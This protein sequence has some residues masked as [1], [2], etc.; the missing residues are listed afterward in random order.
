MAVAVVTR[1]PA[2]AGFGLD[3]LIDASASCVLVW[4]FSMARQ[5]DR[6]AQRI[7]HIVLRSVGV[8]LLIAAVYV[9]ARSIIQLAQ[10]SAS[11]ASTV[12]IVIAGASA[13]VLPGLA[14]AKVRLARALGSPALR[15]DGIL[16]AAAALLAIVALLALAVREIDGLWWIDATAALVISLLL[17]AEGIRITLRRQ[18]ARS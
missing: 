1:S 5:D 16:T 15:S 4:H 6:R 18:S 9:A 12:G 17:A 13:I 11:E 3:A 14:W 8:A 10:G 2:L 7:E